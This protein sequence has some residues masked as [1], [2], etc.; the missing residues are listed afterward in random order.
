MEKKDILDLISAFRNGDDNAF[1]KLVERYSP[2]LN[3]EIGIYTK[4]SVIPRELYVEACIACS[5][6]S[7]NGA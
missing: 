6:K 3:K 7:W 4:G 1:S 2:L 5:C